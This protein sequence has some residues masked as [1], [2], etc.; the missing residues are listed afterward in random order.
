MGRVQGSLVAGPSIVVVLLPSVTF[1]FRIGCHIGLGG[2]MDFG[3]V[4]CCLRPA[5][6]HFFGSQVLLALLIS[7][8]KPAVGFCNTYSKHVY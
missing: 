2:P 1:A 3:R 5:S 6:F 4:I 7:L 8:F